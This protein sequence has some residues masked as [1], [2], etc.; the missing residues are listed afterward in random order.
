MNN[1]HQMQSPLCCVHRAKAVNAWLSLETPK[2]AV[3]IY[4]CVYICVCNYGRCVVCMHVL[5]DV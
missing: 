3:Y 4:T 1:V 2:R 5:I